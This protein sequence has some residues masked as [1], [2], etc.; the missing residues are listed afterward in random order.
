MCIRYAL[1]KPFLAE[2]ALCTVVDTILLNRGLLYL[3][4]ETRTVEPN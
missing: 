1:H 2:V 3:V 4:A